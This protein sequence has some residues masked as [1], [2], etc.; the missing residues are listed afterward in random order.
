MTKRSRRIWLA[1]TVV[2]LI[3][4]AVIVNMMGDGIAVTVRQLHGQ[5]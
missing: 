1:V 4:I 5:P 3:A 2:A